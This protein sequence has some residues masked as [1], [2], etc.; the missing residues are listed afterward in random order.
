MIYKKVVGYEDYDVVEPAIK[1]LDIISFERKIS[2]ECID[3]PYRMIG[4]TYDEALEEDEYL[5]NISDDFVTVVA[6]GTLAFGVLMCL[7]NWFL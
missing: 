2:K 3:V 7:I 5:Y 4:N 6:V 1:D